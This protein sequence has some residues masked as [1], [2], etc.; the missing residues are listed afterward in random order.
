M[1]L[2]LC[3]L[4]VWHL[5]L[6]PSRAALCSNVVILSVVIFSSSFLLVSFSWLLQYSDLRQSPQL[7]SLCSLCCRLGSFPRLL[8]SRAES[9]LHHL[10]NSSIQMLR[11]RNLAS[12]FGGGGV[13]IQRTGLGRAGGYRGTV[14]DRLHHCFSCE[15]WSSLRKC[16]VQRRCDGFVCWHRCLAVALSW[17]QILNLATA[18]LKKFKLES[19]WPVSSLMAPPVEVRTGLSIS[20]GSSSWLELKTWDPALSFTV[21]QLHTLPRV[22]GTIA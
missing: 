14:L 16:S 13:H 20:D 6:S 18:P 7:I 10:R 17:Q 15:K 11:G 1:T 12:W 8:F 22:Q 4:L 21:S 19:D 2:L 3:G 5:A 9:P